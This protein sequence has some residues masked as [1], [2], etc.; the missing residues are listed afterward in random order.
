MFVFAHYLFPE[1]AKSVWFA[2]RSS[3]I[4]QSF[5]IISAGS[6]ISFLLD[7]IEYPELM[8]HLS[9][10]VPLFFTSLWNAIRVWGA[11]EFANG[12]PIA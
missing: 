6:V 2:E 1:L 5:F 9:S 12:I 8:L 7:N 4:Q 11:Q 3:S 10:F